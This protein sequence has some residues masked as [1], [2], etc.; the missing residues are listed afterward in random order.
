MDRFAGFP[1]SWDADYP[2][3][4]HPA[5]ARDLAQLG[6]QIM[7]RANNHALGWGI[8]G[9][10]DT[11]RVLRRR[12][13][14][15]RRLWRARRS[16]AG[17]ALPRD[18]AGPCGPRVVRGDLPAYVRGAARKDGGARPP[19]RQRAQAASQVGRAGR[20][21][22]GAGRAARAAGQADAP[23]DELSPVW[24]SVRT[25]YIDLKPSTASTAQGGGIGA[26]LTIAI[27]VIVA[28]VAVAV[29]V[30]VRRRR[31]QGVEIE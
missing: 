24:A 30:L 23:S 7:S 21:D 9:M 29:T 27:V 31:S 3:A 18:G 19:R 1:H 5:V 6:F 2:M 8:E 20:G 15:P 12:G 28:A 17:A 10:R 25:T 13:H 14:R 16:C 26:G 4:G 22:G 11:S